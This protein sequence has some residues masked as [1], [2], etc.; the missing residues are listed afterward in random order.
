MVTHRSLARDFHDGFKR[1]P[2]RT[3]HIVLQEK[4]CDAAD[5]FRSRMEDEVAE[6]LL[7]G[8]GS[9]PV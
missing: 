5:G 4:I 3:R 1:L 9:W 7:S 2:H 6:G 8:R